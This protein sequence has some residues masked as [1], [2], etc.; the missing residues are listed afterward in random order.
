MLLFWK[1]GNLNQRTIKIEF[2][3][4]KAQK[5]DIEEILNI[6]HETSGSWTRDLFKSEFNNILSNFIIARKNKKIIAFAISWN[7]LDELHINKIAVTGS[8]LRKGIGTGLINYLIEN[9]Q[10]ENPSRIILEVNE[11]NRTGIS[12]YKKLGFMKTGKR[13]NYYENN[14]AVLMEK[15]LI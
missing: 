13:K 15:K 6:E 7:I 12:F 5:K 3:I 11:N 2:I 4:Q 14:D 8:F 1:K 9:S 10:W